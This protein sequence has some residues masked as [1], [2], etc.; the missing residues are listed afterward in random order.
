MVDILLPHCCACV[1]S[2][3]VSDFSALLRLRVV[4]KQSFRLTD[5]SS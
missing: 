4:K 1:G 2:A 3:W 5:F